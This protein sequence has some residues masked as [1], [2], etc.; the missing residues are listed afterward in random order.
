MSK[1]YLP[2]NKNLKLFSR[3][4]RNESTL[5]EALMWKYLRAGNV[6]GYK[7]NRQKPILNYIVDFYCKKLKLIIEI[8]GYIH[9]F[10]YKKDKERQK[11][12]EK[13]GLRFLRFK[14]EEIEKDFIN[15]IRTVNI[16]IDEIEAGINP[17]DPLLKGGIK[18]KIKINY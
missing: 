17:P 6:R 2:Y 4:L 18:E 16:A 11:E 15:I 1:P 5:S 13:I 9:K 12:I 8:D 7:F 10:Q 3:Q 14:D